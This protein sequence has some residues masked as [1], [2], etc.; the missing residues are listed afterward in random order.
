MKVESIDTERRIISLA[1]PQHTYGYRKGQWYYALNALSE[2]DAPG[3]WYLDRTNGILYFYPP[4]PIKNGE[5]FVSIVPNL[6]SVQGTSDVTFRGLV[7]EGSRDT[8]VVVNNATRFKIMACTIRNLGGQGVILS[9]G[10]DS[11][12]VGCDIYQ[13]GKGGISLL[14]GDPKSLT[15]AGL[16]ADNNHI[17]HFARVFRTYN[18]GIHIEGVGNRATH[19]LIDNAPHVAILFSGNDHLIE[20]NEIHN[21]TQESNDAGAIYAGRNWAMRGTIIR[22]NYLHHITGFQGRGSAGVYLD[23]M[24]SGTKVEGNVFYQVT[25][26]ILVGGGRDNTIENNIFVAC[27]PAVRID[28]R[29]MSWA[30]S[31]TAAWVKE[32]REQGTHLG[33]GLLMPP[34]VGRYPAIATLNTGDPYAPEGNTVTRNIFWGGRW[35]HIEPKARPFLG[36]ENNLLDSD[37]RFVDAARM[38]FSL[39]SDSTAYALGF[40]RIPFERIGLN[41]KTAR[42]ARPEAGLLIDS[43]RDSASKSLRTTP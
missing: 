40:Q 35:E 2:L 1:P 30:K 43:P 15:A 37:P 22:H 11:G 3:E 33:I 25:N 13:T 28:A 8:A 23:D 19:N 26:A 38:N 24:Y 29:A 17:H 41:R 42:A 20:L 14:G 6:I 21:V 39:R 27:D 31:F 16:Y 7:L 34:Y 32:L 12:V 4:S 9:G 5:A 18:A 36:I 10:N